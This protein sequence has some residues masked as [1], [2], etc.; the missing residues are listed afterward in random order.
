MRII[1]GS[2]AGTRVA[3]A[4]EAAVL[5]ASDS[6][7]LETGAG[8]EAGSVIARALRERN[9]SSNG[10]RVIEVRPRV[11]RTSSSAVASRG[12]SHDLLRAQARF[13]SDS[14]DSDPHDGRSDDD[15]DLT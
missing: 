15:A 13:S 12:V 11:R 2:G 9:Y 10:E 6:D 1:K 5:E 14:E 4:F 3:G 7:V 8:D